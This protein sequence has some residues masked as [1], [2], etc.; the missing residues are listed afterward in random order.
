MV[1]YLEKANFDALM[2]TVEL[3]IGGWGKEAQDSII[4]VG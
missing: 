2:V 4:V 3:D 1:V